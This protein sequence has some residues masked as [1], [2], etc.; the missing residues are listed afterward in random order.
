MTREPCPT[1]SGSGVILVSQLHL[2]GAQIKRARESIGM[3]QVTLAE[4]IGVHQSLLC[5]YESDE[6]G[7]DDARLRTLAKALRTSQKKLL[8][9]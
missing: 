4:K 7:V 6:R 8:Q 5:R 2:I 9:K 1:C 3:S